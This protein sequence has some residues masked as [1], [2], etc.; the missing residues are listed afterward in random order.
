ME[1]YDSILTIEDDYESFQIRWEN[2]LKPTSLALITDKRAV[3]MQGLGYAS[4]HAN[5]KNFLSNQSF[6]IKL[7]KGLRK[8]IRK[9]YNNPEA[10]DTQL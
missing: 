7:I 9:V 6:N 4:C 8:Q 2:L 5:I 1:A 3:L 10:G